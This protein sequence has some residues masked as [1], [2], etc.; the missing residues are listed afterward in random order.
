VTEA[1]GRI[2]VLED[3]VRH[4]LDTCAGCREVAADE[5]ALGLLLSA[6]V[7]PAD[8]ELQQQVLASLGPARWRRRIVAF[9]PVAASLAIA[10][11]GAFLVGGV[12]GARIVSFLPEWS[13]EGWMAFVTSASDWSLAVASGARAAVAALDP[14]ILIGAAGLSLLGFAGVAATAVRWRKA[15]LWR[16]GR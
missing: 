8:P 9:V 1:G 5:R 6:A 4:H 13:A 16:R 2:E 10:V 14:A 7:P 11:L 12:P 3:Q 15:S